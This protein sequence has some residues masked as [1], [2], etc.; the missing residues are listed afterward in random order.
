MLSWCKTPDGWAVNLDGTDASAEF[1]LPRIELHSGPK[2]WTC[3]CHRQNGTFQELPLGAGASAEVA[4]LGA[5]E[6]VLALGW[7]SDA[8]LIAL[9][10]RQSA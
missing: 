1:S 4:K 6:A 9:L 2:G 5:A 8:H 7:E 3:V 10:T